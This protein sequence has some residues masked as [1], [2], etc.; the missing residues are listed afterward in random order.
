MLYL[1]DRYTHA[2]SQRHI[3]LNADGFDFSGSPCHCLSLEEIEFARRDSVP[4]HPFHEAI[5]NLRENVG[6]SHS[7]QG[8]PLFFNT[9]P[10][11]K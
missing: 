7:S 11:K 4:T 1:L 9:S 5:I 6:G 8:L 10:F 2:C 3:C